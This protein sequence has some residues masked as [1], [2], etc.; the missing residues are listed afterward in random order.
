MME[1][2]SMN[3]FVYQLYAIVWITL[4]HRWLL[5]MNEGKLINEWVYLKIVYNGLDKIDMQVIVINECRKI[6]KANIFLK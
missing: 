2:W 5:L 1:N 6:D 4:I 3:E